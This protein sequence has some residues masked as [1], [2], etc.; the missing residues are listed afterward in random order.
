MI[1][2]DSQSRIYI[3]ITISVFFVYLSALREYVKLNRKKYYIYK[4]NLAQESVFLR[5][6]RDKLVFFAI[7][8]VLFF[9]FL[10]LTA[11]TSLSSLEAATILFI[12]YIATISFLYINFVLE[13][14]KNE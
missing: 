12:I 14:K 7:I 11:S 2:T 10:K 3:L 5:N 6:E 9:T 4:L 1:K 13:G 8:S